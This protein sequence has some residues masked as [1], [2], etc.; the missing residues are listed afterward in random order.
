[1]IYDYLR[2][3]GIVHTKL[4]FAK[5]LELDKS[6]MYQA[7]SG[8]EKFLSDKLFFIRIPSAFPGMFNPDWLRNG[9]GLMTSEPMVP[10]NLMT[11]VSGMGIQASG[12]GTVILPPSDVQQN[13]MQLLMENK[14][15]KQQLETLKAENDRLWAI[16]NSKFNN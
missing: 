1:M 8:N 5:K 6:S 16:I 11:G 4:E 2:S 12:N 9:F 7:F 13:D 15:L 10:Q 3:R 14:L